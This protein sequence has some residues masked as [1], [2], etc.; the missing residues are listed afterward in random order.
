MRRALFALLCALG[1]LLNGAGGALAQ[2]SPSPAGDPVGD[3]DRPS[4]PADP[5]EPGEP[6]PAGRPGS[7]AA[8]QR[9]ASALEAGAFDRALDELEALADRG[10]VHPDASFNRGVAYLRRAESAQARPGDYGRA[11]A[12]M[13]EA[14]RLQ[15][16]D[17]EAA[18]TLAQIESQIAR[19]RSREGRDPVIASPKMARAV[20]SLVDEDTWAW[21]ALVSSL[22]VSVGLGLW[23]WGRAPRQRFTGGVTTAVAGVLLLT[24]S[25]LTLQARRYRTTST[26]AVVVVVEA[27]LLDELGKPLGRGPDHELD[28]LPEG[29]LVWITERGGALSRVEWGALQAFVRSAELQPLAAPEDLSEAP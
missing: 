8:F 1:L 18:R 3:T 24:L 22:G 17:A 26:P 15:P 4:G 10:F 21:L 2:G 25:G 5:G 19:R 6:S 23:L 9:A 14:L 7:Q 11:A 28:A 29:A 13:Q 12:A 27:R 20:V 16:G